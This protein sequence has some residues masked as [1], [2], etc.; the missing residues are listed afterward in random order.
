MLENIHNWI[1]YCWLQ[2]KLEFH[3]PCQSMCLT[4]DVY[5]YL[6][7][8]QLCFEH[9]ILNGQG[10]L[11]D[12]D[13]YQELFTFMINLAQN[14]QIY[15]ISFWEFSKNFPGYQMNGRNLWKTVYQATIWGKQK[16]IFIMFYLTVLI[17]CKCT[18]YSISTKPNSMHCDILPWIKWQMSQQMKQMK[19]QTLTALVENLW[20]LSPNFNWVLKS[21]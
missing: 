3:L 2:V 1:V 6:T 21:L 10:K 14:L 15:N 8:W 13:N 12:L 9:V 19:Y 18:L 11:K 7:S 17:M 5:I 16:S 4:I 20:T